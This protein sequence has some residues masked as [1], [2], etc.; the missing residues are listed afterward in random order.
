MEW[1]KIIIA[2]I[3]IICITAGI[4]CFAFNSYKTYLKF[5]QEDKESKLEDQ[6]LAEEAK[7]LE[8]TLNE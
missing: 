7:K 5:K 4:I 1:Y 6:R 2:V 8:E 3:I